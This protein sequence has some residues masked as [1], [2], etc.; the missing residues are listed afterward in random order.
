[1]YL[2][3]INEPRFELS[4]KSKKSAGAAKSSKQKSERDGANVKNT[5]EKE[6]VKEN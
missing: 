3:Q 1:M 5:G 4:E 6:A 2:Y